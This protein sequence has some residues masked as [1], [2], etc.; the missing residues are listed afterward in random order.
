M[1]PDVAI[2][3]SFEDGRGFVR[4]E[5]G[6]A[7]DPRHPEWPYSGSEN[8]K[9]V[10]GSFPHMVSSNASVDFIDFPVRHVAVSPHR[11]QLRLVQGLA[12]GGGLDYYVIGRLD[13][14]ADR[15]GFDGVRA[16]FRYHAA[17]E[18]AYRDLRS[19]SEVAIL[20]GPRA[21]A[22]EFRGWFRILTEHHLLFDSV[23]I[24]AATDDVLDGYRALVLPGYE[25]LSDEQARRIDRFVRRG[26]TL[27]ATGRA[28]FRDG[29]FEPREIPALE[30][31]GIER[32]RAVHPDM[33]GSYFQVDERDGFDRL[34]LTHLV[35]LD[36][37]YVEAEFE[38]EAHRAMRLVP[39]SPFGPPERCSYDTV[40]D[41]PALT[42]HPFGEG[43]AI[44]VP[45][46]CGTL[47]YRHGQPNTAAFAA[48]VLEQHARLSPL[49]GN[50]SPMV[51]VTLFEKIDRSYRLLH[52]I[53]G[54]GRFDTSSFVPV[55]MR[56]LE[57]TIPFDGEPGGITGLVSEREYTWSANA[58]HLT[59]RVPELGLFEA[60][61]ISILEP[62]GS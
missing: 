27:V 12:N 46:L 20:T 13:D 52:L 2:D 48:D 18:A 34:E 11:Q 42:V 36:G 45:W 28:G 60:L 17:H 5:S 21:N 7:L 9:W 56:D 58:D 40:T 3:R 37:P 59:I 61:R 16:I 54:S 62:G 55:P 6:T 44:Y 22:E 4:Q 47:F 49:G 26:G 32:V 43:R 29:E 25:P 33:R 24:D 35:F 41:D 53:N 50:L 10:V 51:E 19:C 8:T 15:S 38:A 1:R 39:P 31:L 57:V 14:H 30:C 23:V